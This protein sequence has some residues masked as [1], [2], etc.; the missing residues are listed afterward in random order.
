MTGVVGYL[1]EPASGA[2]LMATILTGAA[3]VA[4]AAVRHLLS[5][6]RVVAA[7]ESA[8]IGPETPA[9][10]S[11][12]TNGFAVTP[13]AAIATL[14]DLAARGWVR[15]AAADDEVVVLPDGH[16]VHGDVLTAYEQQVLNHVHRL[17][18]GTVSGVSGAGIEVAGLRLQR[19]WRRR[20]NRAVIADARRQGL[21]RPQWARWLLVIPVFALVIAGLLLWR[22]VRTGPETPV[23]ESLV[24]RS[25]A[26]AI[27]VAIVVSAA[28]VLGLAASQVQRPTE[29]GRR[30]AAF[31]MALRA[32]MEPRGFEGASS[33]AANNPSR[34]LGYAASFGLAQRAAAEVPVLPEDDHTAWSNAAGRWHVVTI[35]YPFRPG[36][37]RHPVLVLAVGAVLGVGIV[38]AQQQLLNIA[39]RH[40]LA[41]LIADNI[42]DQAELVHDIAV[43]IAAA[44]MAPLLWAVWLVVAG[45]FDLVASVERRGLVVRARR[46]QRVVPYPWL[47]GPLARR[48]RYSLFVAVDEGR[49]DRIT[50][51]LANERTAVPQGAR[52]R[53]RATPLL[54]YV[55]AAEPIGTQ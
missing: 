42:P 4:A 12:L 18:A 28:W 21:C 13:H 33:V 3:I 23:D 48:D 30:R 46:P 54:G 25:V 35:R 14:L 34:A 38:L 6:P 19:R 24:T 7:G 50:S 15:I 39:R 49:S 22:S 8:E 36:F 52:A 32:W 11:L 55:R 41:E 51:A 9:V 47:L 43:G 2:M 26:A 31:W 45:A 5:P 44:L 27:A 37:G 16:G 1:T 20:F 17:T 53:V 29:S 10:A 40:T